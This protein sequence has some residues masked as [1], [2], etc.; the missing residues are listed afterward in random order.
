MCPEWRTVDGFEYQFGT[1]HLGHFLLTQLLLDKLRAAAA[2]TARIVNVSS[3]A[4]VQ[5][6]IHFENINLTGC[7]SP[8]ESYA[9][10]KIANVLFSR[11]LARKLANDK[12]NVYSL[13]PGIIS[14]E[15]ARHFSPTLKR[16][17][18]YFEKFLFI[19]PVIGA[20]TTLYC[21]FD[22]AVANETGLFYS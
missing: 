4:H 21:A 12:I 13:H 1:N 20:Q 17:L 11:E 7:Y 16:I 2:G 8:T 3:L 18:V 14:T 10:S 5:G 19:P 15:L 22:E 6:R 9:Q